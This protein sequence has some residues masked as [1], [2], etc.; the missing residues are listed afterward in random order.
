MLALQKNKTFYF[1]FFGLVNKISSH[2]HVLTTVK[3]EVRKSKNVALAAVGFE[4]LVYP[5]I[6]LQLSWIWAR[7]L[8]L[9]LTS[10]RPVFL[11]GQHKGVK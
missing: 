3:P 4:G 9:Q 10:T 11:A 7:S 8:L 6:Y 2:F 1:I 5:R